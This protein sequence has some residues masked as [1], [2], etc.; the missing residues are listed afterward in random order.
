MK[1]ILKAPLA[2]NLQYFSDPAGTSEPDTGNN[3]ESDQGIDTDD[4]DKSELKYSDDDVNKIVQEKLAKAEKKKQEAVD[5]A[6]KLA[7]M[8]KDEKQQHEMDKL[9]SAAQ[10]AEDELAKYHMRDT[11]KQ[12]ISDGGVT[13]TDEMLDLV[14]S[15]D[16]DTTKSN[17]N[18]ALGF[19]KSIREQVTKELSQGT[20]PRTNGVTAMTKEEIMKIED[21][22]ERQ[23]Q[24]ANHLDLFNY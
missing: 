22:S 10:V 11:A 18:K 4:D 12:M 3:G 15:A 21:P 6:K 1:S 20:T 24:I 7:K 14:T 9:K 5:E 2:L 23:K 19:A 17:V 8:T 13:P 16:A